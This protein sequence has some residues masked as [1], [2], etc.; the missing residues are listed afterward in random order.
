MSNYPSLL[1]YL[2][3]VYTRS[4]LNQ[5]QPSVKSVSTY[6]VNRHQTVAFPLKQKN[7]QGLLADP[8]TGLGMRKVRKFNC[9][10]WRGE[11]PY[12]QDS[13]Y[14]KYTYEQTPT[15]LFIHSYSRLP[16]AYFSYSKLYIFLKMF[17]TRFSQNENNFLQSIIIYVSFEGGT[18]Y[19]VSAIIYLFFFQVEENKRLARVVLSSDLRIY[20]FYKRFMTRLSVKHLQQKKR[21][22]IAG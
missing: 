2:S 8:F 11:P 3:I 6:S 4:T 20:A 16:I 18:R 5:F 10:R 15:Y 12:N 14:T 17:T 21:L 19:N 9:R 22:P 7:R 13:H 1:V